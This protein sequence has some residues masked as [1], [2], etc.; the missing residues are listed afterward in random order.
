MPARDTCGRGAS[1]DTSCPQPPPAPLGAQ[2]FP[3]AARPSP[4]ADGFVV[5]DNGHVVP[6]DSLHHLAQSRIG[7]GLDDVDSA[8]DLLVTFPSCRACR[9]CQPRQSGSSPCETSPSPVQ[10]L[11]N[12]ARPS[13]QTAP[14][15]PHAQFSSL[16]C[17]HR[18]GGGS[19][20][21]A[22]DWAPTN[23]SPCG[24]CALFCA[25]C[26]NPVARQ[27]APTTDG[28]PACTN[29]ALFSALI[30][31]QHFQRYHRGRSRRVQSSHTGVTQQT[32]SSAAARPMLLSQFR[33]PGPNGTP[34]GRW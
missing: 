22:S 9:S 31:L 5:R 12:P 8:T 3:V 16:G 34:Q 7:D 14:L 6:A 30:T 21:L 27:P 1:G 26:G 29:H 32:R 11:A 17:A 33:V 13:R 10:T 24:F 18:W 23:L 20:I 15:H 28:A 4:H 19:V 25:L 2:Q